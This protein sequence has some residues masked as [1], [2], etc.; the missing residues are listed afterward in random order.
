MVIPKAMYVALSGTP[1][2]GKTT[3]AGE[4]MRKGHI[5]LSVKDLAIE[6]GAALVDGDEVEVD[7]NALAAAFHGH[8]SGMGPLVFV[9]GHLSH[10]LPVDGVIVLRAHPSLVKKRLEERGYPPEKIAENVEAEAVGVCLVEAVET[11]LPVA[12]LDTTD[13]EPGEAA[14]MV[15][16]I[17]EHMEGGEVPEDFLPGKIDWLEEVDSWF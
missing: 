7:I 9:E 12:E 6:L 1:G 4:L 11:G 3:V 13:M 14:D 10:L 15:L 2:T 5:V 8:V 16:E 17:V